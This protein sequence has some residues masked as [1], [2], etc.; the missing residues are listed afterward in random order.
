MWSCSAQ[1]SEQ[2][3]EVK[4]SLLLKMKVAPSASLVAKRDELELYLSSAK[5][6]ELLETDVWSFKV[7]ELTTTYSAQKH[8]LS[9]EEK[10][11]HIPRMSIGI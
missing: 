9:F 11:F 2:T 8:Q 7:Y 10:K 1:P 5:M 3:L 4:M 6:K